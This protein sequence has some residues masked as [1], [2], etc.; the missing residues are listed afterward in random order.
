MGEFMIEIIETLKTG[1]HYIASSEEFIK[2]LKKF[3]FANDEELALLLNKHVHAI[4]LREKP[5]D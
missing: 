5:N 2:L 4:I 3:I 1:K